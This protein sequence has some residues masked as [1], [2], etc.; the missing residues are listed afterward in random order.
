MT[1]QTNQT[2]TV[3]NTNTELVQK[4]NSKIQIKT[5]QKKNEKII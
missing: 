2:N 1:N 3:T 5:N 4:K